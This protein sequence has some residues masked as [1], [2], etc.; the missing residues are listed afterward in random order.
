[1]LDP[2]S[3]DRRPARASTPPTTSSTRWA[4]AG[5]F[6]EA[7]PRGRREL[8][9]RPRARRACGGSSTS[10]GSA[11]G[12]ERS[13]RTSAAA[14]RSGDVLR[15]VGVPVDRV[16]RLDRHRLGEPV[17]RDDPR[18]RRAAARH[19]HA[20]LGV[21][22]GAAD[23]HRRPARLPGGGARPRRRRA[24][25]IFEIGGADRCRTATHA[26]VCAPARP[27]ALACSRCPC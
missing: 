9:P 10:A 14:T 12:S 18:P 11:G 26:R 13:R 17:V 16:P 24:A 5:S 8:R 15:R 22:A 19:D 23:R 2:A 3:L 4:S 20:A 1:M 27:P 25:A 6:E 21:D 7:G